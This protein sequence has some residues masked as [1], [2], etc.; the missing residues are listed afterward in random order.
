M[1]VSAPSQPPRPAIILLLMSMVNNKQPFSLRCAVLYCFQSYLR[2]H[3]AGQAGIVASLLP[4]APGEP[5]TGTDVSAGQLLCGGL[6]SGEPVSNW[7]CSAALA[8]VFMD[9]PGVQVELLRV[10]LA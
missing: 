5:A 6:F 1:E 9:N 3:P 4:T 8:H 2:R 10:Q 7:L